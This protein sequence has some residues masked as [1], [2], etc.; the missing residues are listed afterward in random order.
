MIIPSQLKA[1][2]WI[3]YIGVN[4]NCFTNKIKYQVRSTED[5]TKIISTDRGQ[6]KL[7]DELPLEKFD[8]VERAV[9][10]NIWGE[11]EYIKTSYPEKFTKDDQE[12]MSIVDMNFQ[13]IFKVLQFGARKYK[14]NNWQK[15]DDKNRYKDAMLRHVFAYLNGEKIDSD[16]GLHHLA[17]AATNCLFLVFF[18]KKEGDK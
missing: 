7:V 8:L 9:R 14:P 6:I 5:G 11:G 13:E 16:S 12:K 4:D 10:K 15:C 2:D 18:D 3:E 17:H 1:N